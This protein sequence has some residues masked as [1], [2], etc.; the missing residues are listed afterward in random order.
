MNANDVNEVD[1]R[2][3]LKLPKSNLGRSVMDVLRASPFSPSAGGRMAVLG[4]GRRSLKEN[5]GRDGSETFLASSCGGRGGL[6]GF[7]FCT[8]GR[9]FGV[10]SFIMTS[11]CSATSFTSISIL[12][13]TTLF[14]AP[15]ALSVSSSLPGIDMCRRGEGIVGEWNLG[16]SEGDRP[17][18]LGSSG[19]MTR[20][21]LMLPLRPTPLVDV[22]FDRGAPFALPPCGPCSSSS[23]INSS[24]VTSGKVTAKL[25]PLFPFAWFCFPFDTGASMIS[26]SSI[27]T[28]STVYSTRGGAVVVLGRLALRGG[29]KDDCDAG[30]VDFLPTDAFSSLGVTRV[31]FFD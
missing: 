14:S 29:R 26:I 9:L 4:G 11:L 21:G 22:P 2:C 10:T 1:A 24:M 20:E 7:D 17:Y 28:S 23:S 30:P 12:F 15:L 13:S 25:G 16:P 5:L 18:R 31:T 27:S 6:A 3:P 19:S 8:G